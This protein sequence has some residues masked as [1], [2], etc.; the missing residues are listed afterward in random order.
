MKCFK[1][2]V[3]LKRGLYRGPYSSMADLIRRNLGTDRQVHREEDHAKTQRRRWLRREASEEI[4]PSE[5]LFSD[6]YPPKL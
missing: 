1:M 2:L 5:T 4:N 3:K 6:F